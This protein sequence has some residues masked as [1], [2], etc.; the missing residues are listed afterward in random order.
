MSD[1]INANWIPGVEGPKTF[2][3]T[4]GPV[5]DAYFACVGGCLC[6]SFAR[7][8]RARVDE[9]G[10]LGVQVLAD[11]VGE[12]LERHCHAH[13]RNRGWPAQVPSVWKRWFFWH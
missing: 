8:S 7:L 13:K 10:S 2:I 3:A 4:Q 11:D 6:Y 5:P 12:Q 9:N 1:Y